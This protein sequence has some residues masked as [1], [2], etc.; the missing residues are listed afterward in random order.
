M[1]A[2][3]EGALA[4]SR[5]A[6][7]SELRAQPTSRSWRAQAW[8]VVAAFVGT[9][10]V[11]AA[12]VLIAGLSGWPRVL[13]RT[14]LLLGLLATGA[15]GGF[16]ALSPRGR[17]RRPLVLVGG[18]A[19]MAALVLSRG[20]GAP[21]STPEWVCSV[22]H[23]GIGL[24]PLAFALWGLRQAAWRWWRALAAGLGAGTAGALLGELACRRGALHVLRYHVG[25]WLLVAGACVLLSRAM[26]PRTFAP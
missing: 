24:L 13:E 18:P 16:V 5:A 6:A 12:A 17:L 11:G 22:S 19:L 23:V 10:L 20:S 26:R 7:L 2:D 25:A 21:S 14:P 3:L 1:S 9:G 8:R 4:R 15:V